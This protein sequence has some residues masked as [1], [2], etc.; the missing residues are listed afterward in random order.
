VA[1][2]E[3]VLDDRNARRMLG[4]LGRELSGRG[5]KA[6]DCLEALGLAALRDVRRD[7]IEHSKPSNP[8]WP[9]IGFV[10]VML[11]TGGPKVYGEEEVEERRGLFH[12]LRERGLLLDSLSR[13]AAGN[14]FR[15]GKLEVEV[16][17]RDR[18]A[19]LLHRGGRTAPF[20]FTEE[21]QARFQRNVS[22]T[23]PGMRKPRALKSARRRKW[24]ARGKESPWNPF[25]FIWRNVSRRWEREGKTHHVPARPIVVRPS[26]ERIGSYARIVR[27]FLGGAARGSR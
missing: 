8:F 3:V 1:T 11:R 12:K 14:V 23:K 7:F 10:T 20:R 22:R 18:R 6:R 27:E 4:R 19:A 16:G 5:E 21:L 17:T 2:T 24:K 15:R 26:P 9:R 25:F 13:G